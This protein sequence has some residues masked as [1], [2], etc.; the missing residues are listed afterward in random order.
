MI[1]DHVQEIVLRAAHERHHLVGVDPALDVVCSPDWKEVKCYLRP[2]T[3][4][5]RD[6]RE[7]H[8]GTFRQHE[9]FMLGPPLEGVVGQIK[10]DVARELGVP[11]QYRGSET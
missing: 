2:R 9:V 11:P 7:R 1:P 4:F 6:P 10:E 5:G 3:M 8:I